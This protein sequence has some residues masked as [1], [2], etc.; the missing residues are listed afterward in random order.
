MRRAHHTS[1]CRIPTLRDSLLSRLD[2]THRGDIPMGAHNVGQ[3]AAGA[4]SSRARR[5]QRPTMC[6]SARRCR[7]PVSQQRGR[8]LAATV[9]VTLPA[10]SPARA[11]SHIARRSAGLKTSPAYSPWR[12]HLTP[13][14]AR[15]RPGDLQKP[16]N[17]A[18]ADGLA[19]RSLC[20][21]GNEADSRSDLQLC[22]VAGAGFEPTSAKPTVL[23][24]AP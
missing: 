24:P 1:A 2:G 5:G 4:G 19:D 20:G 14:T 13:A 17:A 3:L 7:F 11:I 12:R 23:Q 6:S 22:M 9:P 10:G 18:N 21:P 15:A 16:R 8:P